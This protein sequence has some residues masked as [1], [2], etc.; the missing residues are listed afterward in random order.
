[1]QTSKPFI[2]NIFMALLIIS[3]VSK[4]SAVAETNTED[5]HPKLIFLNYSISKGK[6]GK[7]SIALIN[8]IITDGKLKSNNNYRKD[9][10][11]GDLKCVQLDDN[12][13]EIEHAIIESP[14]SK[15]VEYINDSLIFENKTIDLDNTTVSLRLQ[16]HRKTKSIRIEE[17]IDSL[18][19]SSPLMTTMLD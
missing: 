3:C 18:Q 2:F 4:K 13:E 11:I 9:G 15:K 19:N 5:K 10:G 7:K 12:L 14:L 6:N 8:K 1:M 17:I 16:L